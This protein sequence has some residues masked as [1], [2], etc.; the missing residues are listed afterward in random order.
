MT[1]GAS[2]EYL[3]SEWHVTPDYIV[4]NWT[5]ELLGLMLEKLAERIKPKV[6]LGDSGGH[7]VSDKMLFAHAGSLIKVVKKN[8]D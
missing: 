4:N 2:F 3:L 8:G 7:K 5:D 1:V 6:P